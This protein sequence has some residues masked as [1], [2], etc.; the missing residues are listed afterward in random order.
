MY[1]WVAEV[2][3]SEVVS[4]LGQEETKAIV[5]L[6]SLTIWDKYPSQKYMKPIYDLVNNFYIYR[7]E[8]GKYLS[9]KLAIDCEEIGK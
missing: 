7:K 2:A 3:L 4:Q 6:D 8:S 9:P 1:P 5:I